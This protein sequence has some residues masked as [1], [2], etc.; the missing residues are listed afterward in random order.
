MSNELRIYLFL[1]IVTISLSL[2]TALC[3]ICVLK[4]RRLLTDLRQSS[5][6]ALPPLTPEVIREGFTSSIQFL[7]SINL[8]LEDDYKVAIRTMMETISGSIKDLQSF[9][10]EILPSIVKKV[11]P[12]LLEALKGN[13]YSL[14]SELF[15][16]LEQHPVLHSA[17]QR[18]GTQL[19]ELFASHES[20][21]QLVGSGLFTYAI[22]SSFFSLGQDIPPNSPYPLKKYDSSAARA[23]FDRKFPIVIRRALQI[24]IASLG[25]GLKIGKDYVMYVFIIWA[26]S[27]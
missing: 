1:V 2:S 18:I 26:I 20:S 19:N 3:N 21:L 11:D 24:S 15:L 23:Y 7:D 10:T 8:D 16:I 12:L 25:F 14:K 5:L 17:F 27:D 9:G 22:V 13:Y 4:S 6:Q